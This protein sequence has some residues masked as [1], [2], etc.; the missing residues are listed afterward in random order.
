MGATLTY[1]EPLNRRPTNRARFSL[2]IIHPKIVL[3]VAAA[4][5]PVKARAVAQD[6]LLQRSLNGGV[7]AFGF[8]PRHRIRERQRVQFGAMESLIGVNVAQARQES[9]VEQQRLE[10]TM[11]PVKRIRQPLGRELGAERLRA[12]TAGDLFGVRRQPDAPEF[13]RVIEDQAAPSFSGI[14][15]PFSSRRRRLQ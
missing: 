10:L 5:H 14:G 13:A 7:Q 15:D 11:A 12:E 8:L 2:P 1:D 4:V 3:E 6:A 9:L